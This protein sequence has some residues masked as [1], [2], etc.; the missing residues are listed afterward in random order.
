MIIIK[1]A[2]LQ[3]T[4]QNV[5]FKSETDSAYFCQELFPKVLQI[6]MH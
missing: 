3:K 6:P 5:G 2:G 4:C 1:K